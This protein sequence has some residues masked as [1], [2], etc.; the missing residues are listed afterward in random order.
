MSKVAKVL[1][2]LVIAALAFFVVTFTVYFF[3]LDM[4]ATALVEPW[5]KNHYDNLKRDQYI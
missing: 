4:K 2:K 3:T 5:F 1:L